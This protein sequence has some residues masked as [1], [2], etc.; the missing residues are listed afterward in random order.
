MSLFRQVA[1]L[2]RTLLY[3]L[4]QGRIIMIDNL[5]SSKQILKPD[6]Y[7]NILVQDA[8]SHTRTRKKMYIF[9]RNIFCKIYL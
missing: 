4:S 6:K 3:K 8:V 5:E 2:A 7:L 1:P 9:I